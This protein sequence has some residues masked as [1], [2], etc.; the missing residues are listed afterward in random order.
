M[1]HTQWVWLNRLGNLCCMK[2]SGTTGYVLVFI[3]S[4]L[5]GVN[6]QGV[7]IAGV[8]PEN[9]KGGDTLI[10]LTWYVMNSGIH[11]SQLVQLQGPQD[12]S[13]SVLTNKL[14][15]FLLD[16]LWLKF[17]EKIMQNLSCSFTKW[18]FEWTFPWVGTK[19]AEQAGEWKKAETKLKERSQ[20]GGAHTC[21]PCSGR[22]RIWGRRFQLPF[23]NYPSYTSRADSPHHSEFWTVITPRAHAQQGL[24]I[25]LWWCQ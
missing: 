21:A 1:S 23:T 9:E 15:Q 16:P 18:A 7:T 13:W 25:H 11:L 8:D 24:C 19:Y 6:D 4:A 22:S 20:R 3:H 5:N 17:A 14:C 10:T 12:A 2:I